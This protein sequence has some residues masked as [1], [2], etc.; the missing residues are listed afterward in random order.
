MQKVDCYTSPELD[1]YYPA[2]WRASAS[3]EM[4]DG[5]VLSANVRY[6][7]G[8]PHNPL[9]WGQLEGRFHELAAPV[10]TEEGKR[11]EIIERVKRLD[12][13]ESIGWG[14]DLETH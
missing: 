4:M 12:D 6:A 14:D 10:I 9:S 2:E 1:D 7:L 11:I 3:L 8:D 5:R 13:V